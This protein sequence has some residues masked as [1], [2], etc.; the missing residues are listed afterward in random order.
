ML[1]RQ[2][3]E[4]AEAAWALA[5]RDTAGWQHDA[6]FGSL[7]E[8]GGR[9]DRAAEL[10]EEEEQAEGGLSLSATGTVGRP[11]WSGGPLGGQEV[12]S[13]HA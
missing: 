7:A 6:L 12:L 5:D 10:R 13:A 3:R 4:P 1:V 2:Q 8:G 11:R 9:A